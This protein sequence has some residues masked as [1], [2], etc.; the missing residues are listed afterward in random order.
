MPPVPDSLSKADRALVED[1]L[2]QKPAAFT[3]LT[4]TQYEAFDQGVLDE[5]NH[6]L[7]AETGNGKTF[8]AEAVIKKALQQNER[9]AYLVPS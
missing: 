9:V 4:Q 6:L 8:V 5:G 7:L 1:L 2:A 3:D